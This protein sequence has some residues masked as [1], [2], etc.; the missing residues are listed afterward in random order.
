MSLR[1]T[2]RFLYWAVICVSSNNFD[3]FGDFEKRG[4]LQNRGGLKNPS[5][6]KRFE[7]LSVKNGLKQAVEDLANNPLD[8]ESVKRTHKTLFQGV[9]PTW[10][11]K[12]RAETAP[13]LRISR[14][15]MESSFAHP[16]EIKLAVD[17]ALNDQGVKAGDVY[18]RL[19]YAHPFLDGNGRTITLVQDE[20]M[21]RR[22]KHIEWGAM[23]KGEYLSALT[24]ELE[25]PDK[26][27]MDDFLKP[28]V[29][30]GALS[31]DESVKRIES[32]DFDRPE[33]K[34]TMDDLI[35]SLLAQT[36]DPARKAEA[37][38]IH[39]QMNKRKLEI[40]HSQKKVDND[41]SSKRPDFDIGDD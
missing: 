5:E 28:Y 6:V 41:L 15:G 38:R 36:K 16:K 23:D 31:L 21:R 26:G 11:G 37:T 40:I 12:D 1:L 39:A 29:K 32:I 9:Y 17:W 7:A 24:Q 13:D 19:A 30:D 18:G 2:S 14:T 4:Y 25:T 8:Y 27:V 10:A 35:K 33:K 34:L 22:D 3:P 20:V